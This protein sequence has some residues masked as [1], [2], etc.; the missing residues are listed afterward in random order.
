MPTDLTSRVLRK[1]WAGVGL[2]WDGDSG[3]TATLLENESSWNT[4]TQAGPGALTTCVLYRIDYF[5]LS[6]YELED[7]TV[8]PQTVLIGDMETVNGSSTGTGALLLRADLVLTKAPTEADLQNVS[9]MMGW[10]LPGSTNSRFGLEEII[11]GRF[12]KYVQTVDTGL[13]QPMQ[14]RNWGAGDSTAG[15]KLYFLQAYLM[16]TPTS[17]L[18]IP[19]SSIV[20]PTVIGK[21]PDLEYMMRLYRSYEQVS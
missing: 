14:V 5:D 18:T 8:Y 1:N 2:T 6:G 10:Q 20:I 12:T 21:E 9:Q 7:E 11:Y 13:F 16:Y 19:S 4:F 17:G 3:T 15:Q